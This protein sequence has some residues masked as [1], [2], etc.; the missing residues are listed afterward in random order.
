MCDALCVF[1]I[2]VSRCSRSELCGTF[3][4]ITTN[5][6]FMMFHG[7][8]SLCHST[9]LKSFFVVFRT[10]FQFLIWF[11]GF[12]LIVQPECF[13]VCNKSL[14][15]KYVDHHKWEMGVRMIL[16]YKFIICANHML[17]I[18]VFRKTLPEI[19]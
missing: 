10:Y 19:V 9:T 5:Q 1:L 4:T 7:I 6:R 14:N 12:Q 8:G 17:V 3:D 11:Y 16:H 15:G 13:K 18:V 2:I